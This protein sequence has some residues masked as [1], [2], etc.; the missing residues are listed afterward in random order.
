MVAPVSAA[1]LSKIYN[2]AKEGL[3]DGF[4]PIIVW[5]E[6]KNG[7]SIC[8]IFKEL[9]ISATY[10]YVNAEPFFP[11]ATGFLIDLFDDKT[12]IYVENFLRQVEEADDVDPFL[13]KKLN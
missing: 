5:K 1:L 12:R 10:G 8:R 6:E 11:Y 3:I 13:K 9:G 2:E 4:S 7:D